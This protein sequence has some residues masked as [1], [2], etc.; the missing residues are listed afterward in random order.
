MKAVLLATVCIGVTMPVALAIDLTIKSDLAQT[1]EINDN[2][3]L[4]PKSLGTT[5]APV[6]SLTFDVLGAHPDDAFRG[7]GKPVLSDLFR[8][9]RR[10]HDRTLWTSLHG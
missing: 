6:S 4:R 8:P 7:L 10:E 2:R 3:D 5:F 9:G 1:L